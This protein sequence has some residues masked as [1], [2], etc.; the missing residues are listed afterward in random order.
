MGMKCFD[1]SVMCNV[2]NNFDGNVKNGGIVMVMENQNC[3]AA[4]QHS[5]W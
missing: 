1:G 4:A 5:R 3:S 2:E